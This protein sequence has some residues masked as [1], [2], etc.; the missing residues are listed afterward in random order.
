MRALDIAGVR[1]GRL[2]AIECV[3]NRVYPGGHSKRVWKCQCD[4]GNACVVPTSALRNGNTRSCGCL[5]REQFSELTSV[6]RLRHTRLYGV[7]L[8]I[9]NRC[10][11]PKSIGYRLYGGRGICMCKEWR[12]SFQAFHSWA[13]ETGYDE[14]APRG[15]C[16]IDRIDVNGNYEPGNCRWATMAEQNKNKRASKKKAVSAGADGTL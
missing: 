3:G 11:N 16:T 2:V 7:W 5:Q 8:S 9:K 15:K 12:D 14:T 1:F 10:Y 6:H 13:M 4:C